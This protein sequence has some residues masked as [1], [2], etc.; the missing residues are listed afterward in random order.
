[1]RELC[2]AGFDAFRVALYEFEARVSRGAEN[3]DLDTLLNGALAAAVTTNQ[4]GQK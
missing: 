4:K 1:M 3:Y 2:D